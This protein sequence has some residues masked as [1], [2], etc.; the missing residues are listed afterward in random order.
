MTRNTPHMPTLLAL[1]LLPFAGVADSPPLPAQNAATQESEGDNTRSRVAPQSIGLIDTTNSHCYQPD[2]RRNVCY[3]N[4][5]YHQ[6]STT[7]Y[8]KYLRVSIA[9][10]VVSNVQ[11][12]FQK[13]L[14]LP[15]SSTSPGYRVACG[16][17]GSGGDAALG[18]AYPFTISAEDTDGFK[19]ANYGTIYCPAFQKP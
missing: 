10:R 18:A 12:F 8:M 15:A 3:I 17:L 7:A 14:Y 19:S 16:T 13:S 4:W 5:F 11:G 9:G 1:A 6:V 2:P